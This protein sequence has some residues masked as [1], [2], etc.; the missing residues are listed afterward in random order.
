MGPGLAQ[1]FVLISILQHQ[2]AIHWIS[3]L[4]APPLAAH[5]WKAETDLHSSCHPPRA[6]HSP[7]GRL[8]L[9][10][11]YLKENLSAQHLPSPFPLFLILHFSRI[12]NSYSCLLPCA[13]FEESC[14]PS[15]QHQAGQHP[16]GL[17][18][19]KQL[20]PPA[21]DALMWHLSVWSITEQ[22]WALSSEV[23]CAGCSQGIQGALL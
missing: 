9:Q 12:M 10:G 5:S 21:R 7:Q 14:I 22:G 19:G 2:D 1:T 23:K 15:L 3:L 18:G 17:P 6:L 11:M 13:C 16:R 20:S 8:V 4:E